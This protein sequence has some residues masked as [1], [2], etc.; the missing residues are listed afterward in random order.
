MHEINTKD[1]EEII[2]I[3]YNMST[4][5]FDNIESAIIKILCAKSIRLCNAINKFGVQRL[6]IEYLF[7]EEEWKLLNIPNL[8]KK[9]ITDF[10]EIKDAIIQT[11]LY[12]LEYG[13]RDNKK[14][15][16]L[17]KASIHRAKNRIKIA[18]NQ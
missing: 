17:L 14:M 8:G 2:D 7:Q 12:K 13:N 11:I 6:C 16:V 18:N 3:I 5:D 10:Y 9:S 1:I 15:E 4:S